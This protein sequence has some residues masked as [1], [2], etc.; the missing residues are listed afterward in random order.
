M[1]NLRVVPFAKLDEWLIRSE[2]QYHLGKDVYDYVPKEQH[3]LT[4][5]ENPFSQRFAMQQIKTY[6]K[7]CSSH[8]RQAFPRSIR[9]FQVL[10][11][12]LVLVLAAHA[13]GPVDRG[14]GE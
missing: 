4:R 10:E 14:M 8:D 3:P 6:S 13:V 11:L 7:Y 9:A 2:C 12:Y 1:A 5:I